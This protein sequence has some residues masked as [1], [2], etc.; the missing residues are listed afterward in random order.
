MEAPVTGP[1]KSASSPTVPPIAIAAASP[2]A[3][4][5]VA[6]AMMT[7]I[8]KK[9]PIASATR[10]RPSA[11][12]SAT[13][14]QLADQPLDTLVDLVP[15]AANRFEILIGRVVELP[16]LVFL[17]GVDRTCVAAAHGDHGVSGT[18]DLVGE[19]LRELLRHVDADF[20]HRLDDRRVNPIGWIGARGPDVDTSA[21]AQLDEAG[22]HL[23]AACVVHADE[24]DLGLFF[25]HVALFGHLGHHL[26][27]EIDDGRSASLPTRSTAVNIVPNMKPL[28]GITADCAPLLANEIG[29]TDAQRLAALLKVLAEP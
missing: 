7:N 26:L 4:E 15:D 10:A 5:S 12:V 22:R 20:A 29:E 25:R 9:V 21:G 14:E 27:L 18:D 2:T 28:A 16:V 23:A 3:R 6:T 1:P 24:Q 17:A 8:R 11:V 19:R 13:R